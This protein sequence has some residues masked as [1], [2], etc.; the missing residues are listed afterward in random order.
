MKVSRLLGFSGSWLITAIVIAFDFGADDT[1]FWPTL[2]LGL[3]AF[4]GLGVSLRELRVKRQPL[5]RRDVVGFGVLGAVVVMLSVL[6]LVS[7]TFW[8]EPLPGEE[9]GDEA[10]QFQN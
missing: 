2:A 8:G 5:V 6:F 7:V 1:L 10:A 3:P 9:S 4:V